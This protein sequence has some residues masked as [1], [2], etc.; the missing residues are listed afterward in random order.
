ME[1]NLK[2]NKEQIKC[3][4]DFLKIYKKNQYIY[5]G[6]LTGRCNLDIKNVYEILFILEENGVVTKSYEEYCTECGRSNG[7]IHDSFARIP[8]DIFCKFCGRMLDRLQN[9]IVIYKVQVD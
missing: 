2:I 5:P 3:L 9:T 1:S 4:I 6:M 8:D 7:V